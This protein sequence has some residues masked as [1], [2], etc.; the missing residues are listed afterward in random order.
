MAV[1]GGRQL[2]RHLI[3]LAKKLDSGEVLRAGFLEG[4]I[5][6]PDG[7]PVAL[8]AAANEFGRPEKNQPPRPFFRQAIAE[9]GKR[10][11]N[12][13]GKQIKRGASLEDALSVTGAFV[14][15]DIQDSISSLMSP[16]LS[17]N[18]RKKSAKQGFDKPLVDSGHMLGSVDYEVRQE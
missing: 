15:S 5:A 8:V 12:G 14:K 2:A 17:P 9:N 1:K 10:W 13:L 7:A 4:A 16:P 18:T 6:E 11:A 3:E